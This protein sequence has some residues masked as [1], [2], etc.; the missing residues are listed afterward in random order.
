VWNMHLHK[1]LVKLKYIQSKTDPCLYYRK[2]TMRAVY[3]DD[4][5]LRAKA[6]NLIRAA[7]KELS[8]NFEITDEGEVDEYLGVKVETLKDKRVKMSQLAV[9]SKILHL[10]K[11]GDEM[12]TTWEYR[13]IIG[14]LNFLEKSTC[15]DIA[16]AVHQCSRFASD[17][18]ASHKMA[19]L[20]IGR[21]LMV[22]G[23]TGIIFEPNNSSLELW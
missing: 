6:K 1:G 12:Q 10:D 3:I 5:I 19:I 22:T 4:C 13:R 15:P 23:S 14:Q 21:Y 7:I 18:K 9:M 11:G 2:D 16:Y 8:T 20:R 17:P